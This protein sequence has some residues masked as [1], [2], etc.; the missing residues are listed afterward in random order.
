M[1]SNN[2]MVITVVTL[3]IGLVIGGLGGWWVGDMKEDKAST[4]TMSA[5]TAVNSK[6]A[7]LRAN[8]VSLGTQHMDLTYTAVASALQGSA[9]ATADKTALIDNG[10]SIGAAV[11]S[12]YG[13]DAETTFDTVWDIHLTQFVNYAVAA[14]QNDD[15]AKAAALATIDTQYTKPLAAYLAKANPN[16]PEDVLY[17]ALSEHVQMTAKM[18]DDEASGDYSAA[19]MQ[20]TMAN[21][22]IEGLF[23]TLAGGIVKQYPNKF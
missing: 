11:G 19:E 15:T 20:L 4:T 18:I 16:L 10:H 14:S 9:S 7:D 6:A 12:V 2:K 8:L 21:T 17:S 5:T 3:V 23:S 1:E 22:H 13:K